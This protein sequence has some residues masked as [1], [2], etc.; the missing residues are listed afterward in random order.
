MQYLVYMVNTWKFANQAMEGNLGSVVPN[1]Q[2]CDFIV[3]KF[4]LQSCY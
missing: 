4:K 2:N 1:M 3:S